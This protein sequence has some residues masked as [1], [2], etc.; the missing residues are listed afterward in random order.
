MTAVLDRV[1][2]GE[3]DPPCPLC[4]GIV[5]SATVFF[6]E[7]LDEADLNRSFA[8]AAAADVLLAVGTTLAVYP[9]AQMVPIA[10]RAGAKVVIVNGE[11]TEMDGLAAV[12]V[13][14]DISAALD[15]IV[16][17]VPLPNETAQPR[18]GAI[19]DSAPDLGDDE[20]GLPL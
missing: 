4:S 3:A 2:G 18:S 10:H 9:I 6:G 15:A 20:F 8:A 19:F 11:P 7:G 5:K 12:S 16:N 14:G 13:L 17:G 1:R